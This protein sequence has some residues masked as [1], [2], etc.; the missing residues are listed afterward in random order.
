MIHTTSAIIWNII[1]LAI[2]ITGLWWLTRKPLMDAIHNRQQKI[3]N[4]IVDT[5]TQLKK[6]EEQ[7]QEQKRLLDDAAAETERI[8][9]RAKEHS[10]QLARDLVAE[11]E[12]EVASLRVRGQK[13]LQQETDKAIYEIRKEAAKQAVEQAKELLKLRL[14]SEATQEELVRTFA[15]HLPRNLDRK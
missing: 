6:V 14:K 5:D 9:A 10:Q 8:L 7:L 12:A 3:A 13:E 15:E 1:N 4:A 11:T 2:L